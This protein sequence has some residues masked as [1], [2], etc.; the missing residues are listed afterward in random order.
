MDFIEEPLRLVQGVRARPRPPAEKHQ[1]VLVDHQRGPRLGRGVRTW[2][3]REKGKVRKPNTGFTKVRQHGESTFKKKIAEK[4]AKLE[5]GAWE[6]KLLPICVMVISR[7][8]KARL[9]DGK[10]SVTHW[11]EIASFLTY[12]SKLLL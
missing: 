6:E 1:Q 7:S 11:Q 2:A 8:L 5:L 12:P 4:N 3:G 10:T 9:V